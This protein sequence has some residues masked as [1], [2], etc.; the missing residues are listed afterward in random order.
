MEFVF[1]VVDF[2]VDLVVVG[3]VEVDLVVDYVVLCGSVGVCELYV[4][5]I[6]FF[7]ILF[8]F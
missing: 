7:L 6:V 4:R 1:F 3:V 2:E 5:I 8:Y